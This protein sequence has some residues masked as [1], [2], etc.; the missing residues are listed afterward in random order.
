[1]SRMTTVRRR[2]LHHRVCLL[3]KG[4]D[5]ELRGTLLGGTV[6]RNAPHLSR[7]G[8]PG[9]KPQTLP[10]RTQEMILLT[11]LVMIRP[12]T[13]LAPLRLISRTLTRVRPRGRRVE[14]TRKD[15]PDTTEG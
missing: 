4:P 12:K 15:V 1:M 7:L 14:R 6:P 11:H 13:Q 9:Q 3:A 5:T 2:S 10:P 8:M